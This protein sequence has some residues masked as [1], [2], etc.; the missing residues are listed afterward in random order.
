MA[1]NS[2]VIKGVKSVQ[3]T[4]CTFLKRQNRTPSLTPV[5]VNSPV[6]ERF[7]G[8]D[9]KKPHVPLPDAIAA[10][11]PVGWTY[12]HGTDGRHEN[13]IRKKQTFILYTIQTFA[14]L[15]FRISFH[16]IRCCFSL[17]FEGRERY[18]Y[19]ELLGSARWE[20]ES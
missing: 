10:I 8:Q 6:T 16:C 19:L 14:I 2:S 3:S 20:V 12:G 1:E 13:F 11:G 18:R 7:D 5:P 9:R 15:Q 4:V 17:F